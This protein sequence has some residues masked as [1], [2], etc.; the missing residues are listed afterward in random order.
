MICAGVSGRDKGGE[1]QAEE[2]SAG[3]AQRL[4]RPASALFEALSAVYLISVGSSA[5]VWDVERIFVAASTI[6]RSQEFATGDACFSFATDQPIQ[7]PD[8]FVF[9]RLSFWS[10]RDCMLYLQNSFKFEVS[11]R[12]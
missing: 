6:L 1:G 11:C 4:P 2:V 3:D 8:P 7:L 9:Q 10:V 5:R 12:P